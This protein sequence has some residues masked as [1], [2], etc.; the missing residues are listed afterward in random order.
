MYAVDSFSIIAAVTYGYEVL[1]D[2][3]PF[4]RFVK[5]R[6]HAVSRWG[7]IGGTPVDL[8]PICT[9]HPDSLSWIIL[10][11]STCHPG[12]QQPS[13]HGKHESTVKSSSK[14]KIIRLTESK[15]R[16]WGMHSHH[17]WTNCYRP[18]EQKNLLSSLTTLSVCIKKPTRLQKSSLTLK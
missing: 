10:W 2:D 11:Y 16:W 7:P 8:F 4:A 5:E 13:L 1:S 14:C 3:D 12:S 9:S 18:K 15:D 17:D 6:G